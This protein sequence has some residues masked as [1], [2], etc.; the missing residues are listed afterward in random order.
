VTPLLEEVQA[1][2]DE[3]LA[4]DTMKVQAIKH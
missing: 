4:F 2:D 3:R 1:A